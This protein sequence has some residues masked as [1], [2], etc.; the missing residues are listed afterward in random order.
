MPTDELVA[1]IDGGCD[2][3]RV[4]SATNRAEP[5]NTDRAWAL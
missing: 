3:L 4:V 2:W 5:R 1:Y